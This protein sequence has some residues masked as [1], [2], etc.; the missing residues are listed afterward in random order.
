MKKIILLLIASVLLSGASFAINCKRTVSVISSNEMKIEI[1]VN[2]QQASGIAKL[3][4]FIPEGATIVYSKSEGGTV[5]TT[6]N[7]M[8]FTWIELPSIDEFKV[9]YI[10]NMEKLNA[11]DY[12]IAGK[13]SYLE[14]NE[15]RETPIEASNFSVSSSKK[16]TITHASDSEKNNAAR[17]LAAIDKTG[18]I[19]YGIQIMS[20]S[21]QLPANYFSNKFNVHDKIK[22]EDSK[23]E[24]KY[25]IGEFHDKQ[26]AIAFRESLIAK[27][28]KDSFVIALSDIK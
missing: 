5:N 10:L 17:A 1:I 11:G 14:K 28:L 6:N 16:I 4:E 25:I 27:G 22:V 24:F 8:N 7:K 2:R 21:K 3:T 20:T 9:S 26:S 18:K 12:S 13:F 19:V 15:K 23:G